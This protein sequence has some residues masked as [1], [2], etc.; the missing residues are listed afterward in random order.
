MT[1]LKNC[2]SFFIL[3][4]DVDGLNAVLFYAVRLTLSLL[5][6]VDGLSTLFHLINLFY[7]N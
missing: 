4:P 3:S 5:C 7:E 2:L 6:G 1:C